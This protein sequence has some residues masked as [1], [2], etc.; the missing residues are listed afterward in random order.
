MLCKECIGNFS[1]L[2]ALVR[3][4]YISIRNLI[5]EWWSHLLLAG[6]LE[7]WRGTSWC[8]EDLGLWWVDVLGLGLQLGLRVPI[9]STMLSGRKNIRTHHSAPTLTQ[10]GKGPRDTCCV[11]RFCCWNIWKQLIFSLFKIFIG[12]RPRIFYD[13]KVNNCFSSYTLHNYCQSFSDSCQ[14]KIEKIQ[15]E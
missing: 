1:D 12:L 2:Y 15:T 14:I 9:W 7:G 11:C 13:S 3:C 6:W 5:R 4:K 8:P 10:Y